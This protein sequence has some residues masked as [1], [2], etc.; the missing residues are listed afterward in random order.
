MTLLL[1]RHGESEGN[2]QRRI[3][4][5]ADFELTE[6]GRRQADAAGRRLAGAGAVALYTSPL[7]RARAT[8][9]IVAEHTG[10]EVV[11]LLDLR[12]YGF[13]EAQGLRWDEA[14]ERFG[15]VGRNWGTGRVPGE[16]GMP[17]FRD[18]VHRQLEELAERHAEDVAIAV[19]HGGVVGAFVARLMGLD[20]GRYAQIYSANCG[21]T[22]LRRGIDDHTAVE[23][24]NEV[25]HLRGLGEIQ[26]EPWLARE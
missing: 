5:W 23:V 26:K 16:E 21:L 3:Q 10:H 9:E 18:R 24:L 7:G 11:E 4:G 17:A 2:V 14:Q 6:L 12:E 1:L 15:L 13:G 22:S 8:A 19:V 25:C 20:D